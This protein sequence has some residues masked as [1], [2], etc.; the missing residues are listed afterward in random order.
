V[1]SPSSPVIAA[2]KV[3]SQWRGASSVEVRQCG[4]KLHLA[5]EGI[6]LFL[7]ADSARGPWLTEA[8]VCR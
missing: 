4:Q 6:F 2:D 5:P 8:R 7:G 3:Q 1:A